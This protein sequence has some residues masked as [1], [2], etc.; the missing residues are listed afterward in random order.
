MKKFPF[1][2]LLAGIVIGYWLGYWDAY[3][4]E[5]AIGSRIRIALFHA[6]PEGI[7]QASARRAAELRDTI[8]ARAGTNNLP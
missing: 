5:K 4:G 3:R 2:G 6:S 8:Q 7:S 1:I